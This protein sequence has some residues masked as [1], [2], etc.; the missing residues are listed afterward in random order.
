MTN[1]YERDFAMTNDP[2][3]ARMPLMMPDDFSDLNLTAWRVERGEMDPQN[4]LIEGEMPWDRGGVGCHGSVIVDPLTGTWKAYIECTEPEEFPENQPENTEPWA[5]ENAGT[6]R[7]CLFES[8]DGVHWTRPELDNVKFGEYDKTNLIFDL[9]QGTSGYGSIM[10][11]PENTEWPYEMVALREN[12]CPSIHGAPPEG[13]GYYRYRSKDGKKW[14]QVGGKLGGPMIGDLCFIY[15]VGGAL[16]PFPILPGEEPPA[17]KYVSYYRLGAE[18]QPTDHVP[19]Y[20]DC[21]RR[22]CYRATSPDGETWT[23]DENMVLTADESDHRDTQYQECIPMKVPGGYIATVTMYLPISQTLNIRFAA[24]RDGSRWWF[25]NR[26]PCL[27]NPPLG[28]Y[29][30][31]QMWQ[32]QYHHVIDGKLYTYFGGTESLHRQLSDTRA[33]SVQI[34]YLDS[35]ID[36]GAH[37]LPFNGALCRASWTFERLYALV[38]SAGGPTFGTATTKPAD[39]G[40]KQML[41]NIVTRPEKKAG[42]PGVD[43]GYLQVELLDANGKPIPG[44]TREDCEPAKGDH[45]SLALK[46]KGGDKTPASAKQAKFYLK[47]T[48]LYGFEFQA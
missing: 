30:G 36:H 29:G 5:S 17:E 18:R 1:D 41:V 45:H 20:E 25:P 46:W 9:D 11:H 21:P 40:G 42:K 14:E 43:E 44:F 19:V 37:F 31:G 48:F 3:A 23:R 10:I 2:T 15:Q 26:T 27:P 16:T 47:R 38:P 6:R 24:S 28:E 22:S 7:I 33:P 12:W 35:V 4:P 39:I 8:E 34:N 32:S 13:N